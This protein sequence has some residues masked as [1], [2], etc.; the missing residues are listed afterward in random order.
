MNGRL[1]RKRQNHGTAGGK[2]IRLN[3]TAGM[4]GMPAMGG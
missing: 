3:S 1:T 4:G 2:L